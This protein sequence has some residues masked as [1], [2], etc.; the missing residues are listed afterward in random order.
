MD[1]L[2]ISL[3]DHMIVIVNV[4]K[5]GDKCPD[6][7]GPHHYEV[8]INANVV[9]RFVHRRSDGLAVCLRLAANAVEHGLK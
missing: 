6:R 4:D 7:N 9:A 8:R 2:V 5:R 3:G 1:I